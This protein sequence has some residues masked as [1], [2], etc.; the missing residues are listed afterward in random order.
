MASV[1]FH[2]RQKQRDKQRRGSP[3]LPSPGSLSDRRPAGTMEGVQLRSGIL[4]RQGAL[5]CVKIIA[6]AGIA[7]FARGAAIGDETFA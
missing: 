4:K 2:S 1:A 6:K 7:M 3:D 5:T